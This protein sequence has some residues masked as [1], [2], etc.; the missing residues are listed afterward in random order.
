MVKVKEDMTGWV[1]SEHGVPDSRLTIIKQIEDY[2]EPKTKRRSARWL[3][4]CSCKNKIIVTGNDIRSGHTKSCGCYNSDVV[5][6]RCKKYNTYEK[7]VDQDGEYYV[8]FTANTNKEFY[9]DLEDYDKIKDYCW[10]EASNKDKTYFFISSHKKGQNIKIHQLIAGKY[11]D[12]IDRNPFNNRRNNLRQCTHQENCWNR[13]AHKDGSS[14]VAGVSWTKKDK[15]WR[16]YITVDKKQIHLGYF[17]DKHDAIK[18]RL[19]AEQKYFKEFA[20]QQ[21]LYKEYDIAS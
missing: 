13:G 18:A 21:N 10:S 7:R 8:G 2:I 17:D 3:C 12:H 14:G 15:K 6:R 1:M 5:I 9:F 4:E 11:S 19:V 20:P 16:A